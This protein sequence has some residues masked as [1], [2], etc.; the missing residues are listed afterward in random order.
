MYKASC[1]VKMFEVE[2]C[3][4]VVVDIL[5]VGPRIIRELLFANRDRGRIDL[6]SKCVMR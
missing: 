1:V 6:R 2:I 3:V 5:E 4:V